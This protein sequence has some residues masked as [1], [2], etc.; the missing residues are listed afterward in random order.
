MACSLLASLE[1]CSPLGS[2]A[3]DHRPLLLHLRPAAPSSTGRGPPRLRLAAFATPQARA[4]LAAIFRECSSSA[5]L[6]DPSALL[7]WWPVFKRSLLARLLELAAR[8]NRARREPQQQ[9]QQ[10]PQQRAHIAQLRTAAQAATE[11]ALLGQAAPPTPP[12]QQQQQ[13]PPPAPG[14]P[15][16][17]QQQH[18]LGSGPTAALAA[19]EAYSVARD[20]AAVPPQQAARWRWLHEGERASP[21]MSKLLRPPHAA[22]HIPCL[23]AA[24]GGGLL[25]HGPHMAELAAAGFASVSAQPPTDPA[26]R[27]QVL[28]ALREQAQPI[29]AQAAAAAGD[30]EVGAQEVLAC[31]SS[32]QTGTAPGPDG[33]PS[34]VW[35]WCS[36]AAAPLLSALFSAMGRLRACAGGFLDGLVSPILKAGDPSLLSNY[37]PITLLN[38]D[39]RVLTKVM[40]SRWGRAMDGC[41]GQEQAAFLPGRKAGDIVHLMQLLPQLLIRR[42]AAGTPAAAMPSQWGAPA[43]AAAAPTAASAAHA[44]PAVTAAPAAA[45]A[46]AAA[47]AAAPSP[48]PGQGAAAGLP[49]VAAVAAEAAAAAVLLDFRKAYDTIDRPF[50]FAALQV[51]G[52]GGG[53]LRWA[54]LLL[55]STTARAVVNGH[56]S[57]KHSWHAGVR[58]GCPLAP[59]MYLVVAWALTSWL[60]VQPGV[61]IS[62]GGRHVPA[63]QY[64]D[65]TSALLAPCTPQRL[66]ALLAALDTFGKASGQ[67]L[68]AA[69]CAVVRF[70]V[71]EGP[72]QQQQL[73]QQQQQQGPMGEQQQQQQLEGIPVVA[74]AKSLGVLIQQQ[75]SS[76]QPPRER[77]DWEAAL[78]PVA[79]A[80]GKL[81]RLPLT[82][83]GR[84]MGAS[85]YGLSKLQYHAEFSTPPPW[86]NLA[87]ARCTAA[88]V[89][90][91]AAPPPDS[92]QPPDSP[93]AERRL[94]APPA[95]PATQKA[96]L[97]MPVAPQL[98]TGNPKQGGLGLL[99]W[100]AHIKARHATWGHALLGALVRGDSS[101]SSVGSAGGNG[102]GSSSSSSS[103]SSG[104]AGSSGAGGS[105]RQAGPALWVSAAQEL[106]GRP[107]QDRHR[108]PPPLAFTFL[109]TPLDR[110]PQGPL[111]LWRTALDA[112]G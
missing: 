27:E 59:A 70:G 28:R 10:Q 95:S 101:S 40:A 1:A 67:Q 104:I 87:L 6:D 53:M 19:Q 86:V 79:A 24:S 39:Y 107:A 29:P 42:A 9:Q 64:A 22:R 66:Q 20:Q 34:E 112:L 89:D 7:A 36:S 46:A 94:A 11:A 109:V 4:A 82:A 98:L 50:L 16:Q 56:V 35:R 103:S 68:N 25:I 74:Q 41:V 18:Q 51:V 55:S 31:I 99:P 63:G 110:L 32:L 73:Q 85:A 26:A 96:A 69:K 83:F 49:T 15:Q 33:L 17:G 100:E 76:S 2:V 75:S 21:L 62:L 93:R 44:A 77:V 52:A 88:L 54:Q 78:R 65:D 61:G 13:Q 3:P 45:A 47:Q 12:P 105:S 111:R 102:A 91:S 80:C 23:R 37:R 58:Q 81:A 108:V 84:A 57:S 38:S 71:A 60:A 5:P 72:A 43:A 106:L 14:P 97:C 8:L 90:S 30:C 48:T 92:L